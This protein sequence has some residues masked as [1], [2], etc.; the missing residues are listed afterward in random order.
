MTLHNA[1]SYP[2][3]W[4]LGTVT[5]LVGRGWWVYPSDTLQ[6]PPIFNFLSFSLHRRSSDIHLANTTSSD[7][8]AITTNY[9]QY[10]IAPLARYHVGDLSY[11]LWTTLLHFPFLVSFCLPG[12][13]FRSPTNHR[14]S[15]HAIGTLP[16]TSPHINLVL[17]L[18]I[19]CI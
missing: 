3:T 7:H 4:W 13:S 17:V 2:I 5:I 1:T 12:A 18:L 10:L 6:C 9:T 8:R 19:I 16:Y 15:H 11:G 14:S